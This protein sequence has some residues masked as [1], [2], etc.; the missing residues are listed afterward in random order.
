MHITQTRHAGGQH[1]I[2]GDITSVI[3]GVEGV[4]VDSAQT[5]ASAWKSVFDPFLR[6]YA[7]LREEPFVPFD[8]RN[9][10]FRY[11]HC[12]P[13]T[14]GARDFLTAR[15]IR[16]PYDDLRGLAMRHEEFFLAEIRRNGMMPY[17]SSVLLVRESH[18]RGLRTAAVSMRRNGSEMLRRAGV[19]SMFDVVLDGLDAPGSGLVVHPDTGLFLHAALLLG[20]R[21]GHTAVVDQTAAAVTAARHCGFGLIVG[22]DRRGGT[23]LNDGADY[24]VTDLSDLHLRGHRH[25]A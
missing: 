2:G 10:Y 22:V 4:V 7:A 1:M 24:V 18:R 12:K 20:A 14:A 23:A 6:S 25:A 8:V 21:P 16:L 5:S 17:A 15:G 13:S 9:D 3:F 19:A 11:L